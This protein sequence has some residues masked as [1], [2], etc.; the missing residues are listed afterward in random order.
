M[1]WSTGED[2]DHT[3]S[4]L[5]VCA[6]EHGGLQRP[7]HLHPGE[8]AIPAHSTHLCQRVGRGMSV[9]AVTSLS[10]SGTLCP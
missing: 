1:L 7:V 6:V 2:E 8:E 5:S 9:C 4:G 3:L 10:E